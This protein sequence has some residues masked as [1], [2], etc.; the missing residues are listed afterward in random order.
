MVEILRGFVKNIILLPQLCICCDLVLICKLV[1]NSKSTAVWRF[2]L[3]YCFDNWLQKNIP[4][5]WHAL[6]AKLLFLIF[7]EIV[8]VLTHEELSEYR[9]D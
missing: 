8:S 4:N 2:G 1:N 3:I 6:F 9:V 7:D 5:S